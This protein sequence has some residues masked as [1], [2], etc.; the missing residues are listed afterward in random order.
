MQHRCPERS[1]AKQHRSPEEEAM[2]EQTETV[3]V[4]MEVAYAPAWLTWVATTTTCLRALKVT[5][6][7]IDV[8]GM[9]GYAFHL[10]VARGLCPSG[11]TELDWSALLPGVWRLGRMTTAFQAFSFT[12]PKESEAVREQF[13]EAHAMARREVKGGRPCVVWGAYVP[14]FAAVVGVTGD[15][16]LV[17]S[18][19][20]CNGEEQPP[21][22]FDALN[23][24]GGAY[25]LAFPMVTDR[26]QP[27]A[28]C[29]AVAQAVA[30]F[31]TPHPDPTYQ[32]GVAA[33]DRWIEELQARRA[34]AGGNSYNAACYAEGRWFAREFLERVA[35]RN[36]SVAG[37]LAPAI[38]EYTAAAQAMKQVA[39]LFPFPGPWGTVVEDERTI[40]EAVETL[41]AARDAESRAVE[42]LSAIAATEWRP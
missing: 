32:S 38:Q 37:P 39:A 36:P 28:D 35:S 11:P 25:L 24:P 31:R 23:A 5:C 2:S 17:K 8:A 34:D 22:P 4:P 40:G 7:Q 29:R 21:I 15:S 33:Y 1:A 42:R 6:D 30:R 16:Y 13:R 19:R 26:P 12:G 9:T 14:E 18:F 10:V 20:E 41:R 3:R 27:D